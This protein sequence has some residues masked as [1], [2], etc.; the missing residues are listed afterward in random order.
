[1]P[2]IPAEWTETERWVWERVAAGEPADLNARDQNKLDP[3]KAEGW[4]AKR[5]LSA[6]FLQVIL[7]Q[8]A[9]ADATP[10][11]G[12]RIHGALIDDSPLNLEHARLQYQFWLERSRILMDVKGSCLRVDGVF[13]LYKSFVAGAVDLLVAN[14][15]KQLNLSSATFEGEVNLNSANVDGAAFLGGGALFKGGLDLGSAEI[16][17]NLEMDGSTFEG[18]VNL[19]GANVDGS[20]YL[21]G[22]ATFKDR[23]DLGYAK[24]GSNLEMSGSTFEG[25]VNL[26]GVNVGGFVYLRGGALFKGGLNLGSAGIGSNLETDGSTFEGSVNLNSANVG[27]SVYLRGG[28][29]FK[30]WLDLVAA[31]IGSNLETD[32]S[33]FE[34]NVTLNSATVGGSVFLRGGALF[35]GGLN[36]VAAKIGSGLDMRGSTFEAAIDLTGCTVTRDFLLG[37]SKDTAARWEDD[38]SLTLRNTKV[39]ALQ[40][41]WRSKSANAWPKTYQIEGFVYDRLGSYGEG[42]EADMLNRP[43]TSYINWLAR[44]R[45]SSP[46]PYEHLARRFRE[47]GEPYKGNVVLYEAR[48]RRRKRAWSKVDDYGRAKSREWQRALGLLALRATI[49]Y[50]LGHRYFRVLWWVGGLTLVGTLVLIFFGSHSLAQWLHVFFAS[51]D[52]LL[53]VVT[54][55]DAHDALIF[56]NPSSNPPVEPQCYGVRIYF[57]AHKIAGWVLGS[58]LVAGLAGLTQRN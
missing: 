12:V 45:D 22:G 42:K 33:T 20:I 48:E 56:G 30:G 34:G 15:R 57:Y 40:D 1:M 52:Q 23:L 6:K 43:V 10:Y 7:T 27:G 41:W 51:L 19:N 39:G 5:R 21:R 58:F 55:D 17:S 37:S 13:S 16:G 8:K 46:Q 14:I 18:N 49:G 38:A 4:G 54:L 25:N 44:D 32:G 28:A 24:I 2:E 31:R 50:G 3:R 26:N 29:L 9:F 47:A 11:S 53:P 35:K 36:L